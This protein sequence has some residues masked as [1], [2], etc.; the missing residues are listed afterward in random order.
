MNSA[1]IFIAL[2][3]AFAL[4]VGIRARHGK[5]MNLEQWAVGGRGFG[6][7]IVFLLM[8]GE[9]YTTFVF[10]GG[11]GF[12]YGSGAGAYYLLG[13]GSLPFV[14]SY[15]ILPPVWRYAKARGL[16]SQPD[17]FAS[18]Y[19]SRALG[20]LV[21]IVGFIALVPYLVLQLKGLGIIVSVASYSA[22]SSRQGVIIGAIVVA[23]YV[24]L[25]GVHG[26]AWTSVI[27]DALVMC[28]AIF[29]G[30][31]LPF[32]YYG[33]VQ[34]MFAAIESAKPGFLALRDVGQ[35]PVWMVSTVV[36]STLGFY[37]WPHMFMAVYTAKKEGVLRK[38][39]FVLP[40]YQ[41]MLLFILF[42]GY[43]A[44]LQVPGLKGGDTDLALF[45][46]TLQTFDPWFVGVVGAAGILTALVPGSMILMTSATLL[47]NNVYRPLR[48]GAHEAHIARVAKWLAPLIMA[49]AVGFT[50][51][52]GDT[53][54]ALLLMAYA[55]V[56]QLFPVFLASLLPRNPVT[57][58]AAFAGIIV[59]VAMVAYVSLAKQT[60]ASMFPFLPTAL[61]DMNVGIVALV[62]NVVVMLAVAAATRGFSAPAHAYAK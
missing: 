47:A 48:A 5:D 43:A 16:L 33:G 4:F 57:R 6:A 22:I 45:K 7:A 24:A 9:I 34:D 28:V 39:A 40:I 19:Q 13:Y 52:G 61:K 8:A 56:T 15:F 3:I 44:V 60:V 51:D 55:F 35:S 11:S 58:P 21:A 54:V 37:M 31:Y 30:L 36:L 26:S 23:I 41:L 17:F 10:L 53:I 38:N 49:V 59:G 27:K 20:V 2:A 50:L 29:L 62:F 25:S 32:H 42:V 14:L 46:I 18:K 12:A 1:L